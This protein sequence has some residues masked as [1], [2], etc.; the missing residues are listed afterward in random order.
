MEFKIRRVNEEDERIGRFIHDEFL[1]YSE[2]NEIPLD[3]DSFCYTAENEEGKI[4]GVITGHAFYDEVHISDLVIDRKYRRSG[5]GSR[6]VRTVEDAYK[7]KGYEIITLSTFAFQAPDFYGKLGYET[8]FVRNSKDSK[9][10]RYFMYKK[11]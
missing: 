9:L 5:L 4:I 1:S 10:N 7:G 11:I 3:Y 2:E 8:E 6:L